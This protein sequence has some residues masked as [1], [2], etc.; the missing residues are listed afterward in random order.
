MAKVK[1]RTTAKAKA[2]VKAKSMA[3]SKTK[4]AGDMGIKR[5][6]LT[7]FRVIAESAFLYE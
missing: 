6:L 7:P 3:K 4:T 1:A 2:T 5:E